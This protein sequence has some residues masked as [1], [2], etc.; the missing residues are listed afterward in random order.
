MR[1]APLLKSVMAKIPGNGFVP[2]QDTLRL[3]QSNTLALKLGEF[4]YQLRAAL[5]GVIWDAITYRQGTEP[6]ADANGIG[7]PILNGK[8]RD[9]DK[10]GF[11]KFPFPQNLA[12]WLRSIQPGTADTP[13]GH[14]DRGMNNTLEDIHNVARFDRHRRLRLVAAVPGDPVVDVA[15]MPPGATVIRHD[16]LNCD[17]LS[18]VYD[19][20][21][22]ELEQ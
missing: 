14:P 6:P 18:G 10:C 1:R 11:H 22:F 3:I 4:A 21:W 15:T 2:G 12:D 5:D 8:V 9:F 7:F 17:P 19:Y 20:L 13:I 16:W